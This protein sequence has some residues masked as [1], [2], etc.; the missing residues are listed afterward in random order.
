MPPSPAARAP[1]S[2]ATRPAGLPGGPMPRQA[3]SMAGM[4]RRMRRMQ[5]RKGK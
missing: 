2:R 1:R 3:Q 4:N 5:E